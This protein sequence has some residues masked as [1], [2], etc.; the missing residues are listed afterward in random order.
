MLSEH[1]FLFASLGDKKPITART[2]HIR[3][4]YDLLQLC[5]QR[6]DL[7]RAKRAWT[8]LARCQE[9]DWKTMWTT[10]VYLL[11]DD[12]NS[13]EANLPRLE[14]LR[15][16]MLQRPEEVSKRGSNCT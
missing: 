5:I 1:T 7:S 2:V 16:M 12:T 15:A 6:N 13:P 8:I 9:V 3:R 14:F 10:G 11:S 4:L